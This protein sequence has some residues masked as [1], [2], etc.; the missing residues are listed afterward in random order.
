MSYINR[1][2]KSIMLSGLLSMGIVT[3]NYVAF[4][5]EVVLVVDGQ[6]IEVNSLQRNVQGVLEENEIDYDKND[7]INQ[8]LDTSLKNGM[9]IEVRQ[10]EKKTI[11]ETQDIPYD[12]V[13]KKDNSLLEGKIEVSQKGKKVRESLYMKLYTKMVD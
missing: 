11:T 8:D 3:A 6:E 2:V 5:K 1:K 9:K 10:V 7:I 4:N 13:I 12:T